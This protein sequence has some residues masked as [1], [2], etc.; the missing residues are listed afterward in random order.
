MGVSHGDTFMFHLLPTKIPASAKFLQAD[1]KLPMGHCKRCCVNHFL[2]WDKDLGVVFCGRTINCWDVTSTLM[3][4]SF[5]ERGFWEYIVRCLDVVDA[6][7][8][9]G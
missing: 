8:K 2:P 7:R 9:N 6:S 3:Q 4:S 5:E 1:V